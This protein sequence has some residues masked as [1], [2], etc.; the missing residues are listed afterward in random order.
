MNNNYITDDQAK[1]EQFS[2]VDDGSDLLFWAQAP[3][4]TSPTYCIEVSVLILYLQ[5]LPSILLKSL[6]QEV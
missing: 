3:T 2:S 1:A 6:A 5:G 4:L